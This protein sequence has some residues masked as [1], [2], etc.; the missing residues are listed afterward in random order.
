MLDSIDACI[1]CSHCAHAFAGSKAQKCLHPLVMHPRVTVPMT[2]CA[3]C[4]PVKAQTTYLKGRCIHSSCHLT[5]RCCFPAQMLRRMARGEF[6]FPSYRKVSAECKDLIRHMLDPDHTTVGGARGALPHRACWEE[7]A[8]PAGW[9]HLWTQKCSC[10]MPETGDRLTS[11]PAFSMQVS[12]PPLPSPACC[13]PAALLRRR[14]QAPPLVP[15]V[16]GRRCRALC[17]LQRF[18]PRVGP[19]GTWRLALC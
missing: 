13:L 12:P 16:R 7:S 3:R 5:Y 9:Q 15:Q 14:H 1:L 10:G 2:V 11:W 8:R 19:R 6:T 4:H 17:C 18:H